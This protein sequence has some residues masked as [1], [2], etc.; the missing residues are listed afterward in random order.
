[1][2]YVGMVC[3]CCGMLV[4]YFGMVCGYTCVRACARACVR[5]DTIKKQKT[6]IIPDGV[7]GPGTLK[8]IACTLSLGVLSHAL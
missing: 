6:I 5:A 2:W 8:K 1:M 7:M 3:W 4:W